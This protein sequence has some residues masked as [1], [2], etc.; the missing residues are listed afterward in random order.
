MGRPLV[1]L[2]CFELCVRLNVSRC[3]QCRLQRTCPS[4]PDEMVHHLLVVFGAAE[5]MVPV[6]VVGLATPA[7]RK[8]SGIVDWEAQFPQDGI[9]GV[10]IFKLLLGML[11]LIPTSR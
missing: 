8:V 9:A 4:I 5:G 11:R 3:C 7:E 10:P 2:L 6:L 1:G